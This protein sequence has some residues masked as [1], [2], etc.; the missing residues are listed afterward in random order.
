MCNAG[1][2]R[3]TNADI[4]LRD[5]L[6]R[7]RKGEDGR[8]PFR[9]IRHRL[10]LSGR[11]QRGPHRHQREGKV[12]PQS[13]ALGHPARGRRQ[14]ARPRHGHRHQA[15]HRRDGPP[16]REGRQDRP[17][18]PQN[19]RQGDHHHALSRPY[20]LHRRGT[21]CRQEVRLHPPRHCARLCRQVHEKGIPHGRA[22]AYRPHVCARQGH[23]RME[24]SHGRGRLSPRAHHDGGDHRLFKDVRRT[25]QR[26]HLRR[27]SLP[28]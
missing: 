1:F 27:G 3:K 2:G 20:G 5:Q 28:Q 18:K 15:S 21:P 22:P 13:A 7:R 9:R 14:R 25:P 12:H 6:G 19:K 10:P 16:S 23:R 8:L 4:H 11:E 24:E 17:R 26:L